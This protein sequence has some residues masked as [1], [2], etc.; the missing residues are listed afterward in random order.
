MLPPQAR[1]VLLSAVALTAAFVLAGVIAVLT[2]RDAPGREL[3]A[4]AYPAR[5]ARQISLPP[6]VESSPSGWSQPSDIVVLG[7]RSFVLD[8]GNNRVLELNAE[9]AIIETLDH[10]REPGLALS[11]PMA[12][13]SDGRNL[14][15]ANSGGAEVVVVTPEGSVVRKFPVGNVPGDL[16]PARPIGLA[17]AGNGGFVVSDAANHRVERY[18]ANGGLVWT[19]GTGGRAGGALGFNTPGGVTLDAAGYVYV[20]DILNGRVVKLSPDGGYVAQY[21]R[22]GNT[23]GALSRPKDVAVDGAGNVYVSDGLL[24]AVQVFGASGAYRGFIG[25]KDPGNRSSGAMFRSPAGLT[26]TG[27][28]LYVVDRFSG[29]FMLELPGGG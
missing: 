15:V 13:A 18:D 10:S 22:L 23:G 25:L 14:Y 9:G 24:D 8:T 7:G 26:I 11:G 3:S 20:V 17:V 5:L 21:G 16:A 28:D 12:I 4:Q 29:V 27:A 1:V 19:A 6:D 2:V